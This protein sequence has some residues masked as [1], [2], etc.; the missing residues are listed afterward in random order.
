VESWLLSLVLSA[1]PV[2]LSVDRSAR[3]LTG[4]QAIADI[5]C[6]V[7]AGAL[8]PAPGALA[9]HAAALREVHDALAAD[10]VTTDLGAMLSRPDRLVGGALGMSSR[11]VDRAR[12]DLLDRAR[13]RLEHAGGVRDDLRRARMGPLDR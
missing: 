2:R 4:A 3:Q 7:L 6:H 5:D 10:P 8:F 11:A 12:R 1:T 9:P 13:G